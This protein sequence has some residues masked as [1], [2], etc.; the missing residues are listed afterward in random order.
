M[1]NILLISIVFIAGCGYMK[2]IEASHNRDKLNNLDPGM[3]SSKVSEVMGKPYK[4]EFYESCEIWFYIT[5]WQPDGYTTLDEMTPLVFEN[6]K[7]IG[8]GSR[9]VDEHIKKYE[10]RIR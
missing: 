6:D 10:L 3:T 5:D 4:R 2:G 7:L 9:Y 8:W 1:K